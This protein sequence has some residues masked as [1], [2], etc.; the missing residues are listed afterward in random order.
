[1]PRSTR[2]VASAASWWTVGQ[3]G[4]VLAEPLQCLGNQ[5]R[6]VIHPQHLRRPAGHRERRL[7]LGHEEFGGD[8]AL[9]NVQ[10]QLPGNVFVKRNRFIHSPATPKPSTAPLAA[11]SH[12]LYYPPQTAAVPGELNLLRP[13]ITARVWALAVASHHQRR[14]CDS[15]YRRHMARPLARARGLFER[16]RSRRVF[17]Y[18]PPPRHRTRRLGPWWGF[19][20]CGSTTL[21]RRSRWSTLLCPPLPTR[22]RIAMRPLRLSLDQLSGHRAPSPVWAGLS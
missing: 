15:A 1:M 6:T 12:S 14:Q 10:Q 3:A 18:A 20:I 9:H 11:D 7:E 22:C 21:T 16:E 17:G 5:L 8:R 4:F 13:C 19:T 2:P